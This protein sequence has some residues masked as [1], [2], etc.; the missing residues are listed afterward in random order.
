MPL[1]TPKIN[2]E[3]IR[4]VL[5]ETVTA[6]IAFSDI[7]PTIIVSQIFKSVPVSACNIIGTAR[8]KNSE[9]N[10]LFFICIYLSKVLL[11]YLFCL[12]FKALRCF[13]SFSYI[14][15]FLFLLVWQIYQ[16]QDDT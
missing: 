6:L 1:A 2:I 7:F 15:L 12:P 10:F 4:N 3:K 9:K 11:F 5:F 16:N 13:L 8:R 14:Y